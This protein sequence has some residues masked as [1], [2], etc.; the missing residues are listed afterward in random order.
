[1]LAATRPERSTMNQLTV[2]KQIPFGPIRA[3]G[4]SGRSSRPTSSPSGSARWASVCGRSA[5]GD[6]RSLDLLP[7]L[8]GRARYSR[9][10]VSAHHRCARPANSSMKLSMAKMFAYAPRARMDE[11][12]MGI[13][14]ANALAQIAEFYSFHKLT[15]TFQLLVAIQ[16]KNLL[17]STICA[18]SSAMPMSP[19]RPST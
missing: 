18:A 13:D 15:E 16:S 9:A 4:C 2:E 3:P 17:C 14:G 7:D 10:R 1:M 6:H 12:R 11:T 5:I 19:R 8:D